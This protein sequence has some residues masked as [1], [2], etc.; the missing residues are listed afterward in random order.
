MPGVALIVTYDVVKLL[1]DLSFSRGEE[2]DS[3]LC[4]QGRSSLRKQ[5]GKV[6]L[7][8]FFVICLP[9]QAAVNG[10][11]VLFLSFDLDKTLNKEKSSV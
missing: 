9:I 2:T 6:S 1:F 4:H 8:A 3:V 5:E 10:W 7:K 11:G